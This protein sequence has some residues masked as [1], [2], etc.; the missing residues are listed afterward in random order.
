MNDNSTAI[1]NTTNID[2]Q[3]EIYQEEAIA[4]SSNLNYSYGET[5][6]MDDME[7]RRLYLVYEVGEDIFENIT[8]HIMRYNRAD[9]GL[10]PEERKPIFLYIISGGGD[11][12]SGLGLITIIQNSETPVYTIN[13]SYCCSMAFFIF[14]AGHK[15]FATLDSVF[16]DHDGE[17]GLFQS[18][19]KAMDTIKF[20]E[21]LTERLYKIIAAKSKLTIEDLYNINREEKWYF[22]NEA[23]ELGLVDYI[24]GE[25]CSLDEIL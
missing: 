19:N 6:T 17:I 20:H 7:N 22:G 16:L 14:E 23:K 9:K 25:D 8:Y 4:V 18:F 13:T 24:I 5:F 10:K 11:I 2:S 12:L 21:K 15:R 3:N 1:E